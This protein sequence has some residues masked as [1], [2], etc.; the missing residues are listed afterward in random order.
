MSNIVPPKHTNLSNLKIT[1]KIRRQLFQLL[2]MQ[3]VLFIFIIAE[4]IYIFKGNFYYVIFP[5]IICLILLVYV[6]RKYL[7]ISRDAHVHIL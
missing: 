3:I 4:V 5:L 7:R 6:T 1:P 2:I